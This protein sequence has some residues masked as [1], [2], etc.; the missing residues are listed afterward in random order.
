MNNIPFKGG[1]FK[2][3]EDSRDFRITNI[4]RSKLQSKNSID[5]T[6]DMT[7]VKNQGQLGACVGFATAAVLEYQQHQEYLKKVDERSREIR[8]KHYDLSEQWIYWNAKE[9][10]PW[11]KFQQG[12]SARYALKVVNKKG[13]PPESAWEY[14]DINEEYGK[15]APWANEAAKWNKNKR[16]YRIRGLNEIKRTLEE[17]GPVIA[18]VLLFEE[19]Y[20]PNN[21]GVISYPNNKN[22]EQGGHAIALVGFDDNRELIK[23]KNSWSTNWGLGGY[24]YLS[25][26]YMND[27][28]LDCW[29]TVDKENY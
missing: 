18:G 3:D 10:D 7:P 2:D 19:F 5:Y 22:N 27:F 29:V 25:Y 28:L 1:L 12:T 8:D 26:K 21:S 14:K 11:G 23:F 15:P 24:G 4:L 20:Y 17:R 6:K 13:V 16:Y 9:I